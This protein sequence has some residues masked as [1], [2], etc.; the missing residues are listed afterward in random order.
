MG[1]PRLLVAYA[2]VDGAKTSVEI[3]QDHMILAPRDPSSLAAA[4]FPLLFRSGNLYLRAPQVRDR[5]EADAAA[6]RWRAASSRRLG[7]I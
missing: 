7:A 3:G 6:G 4:S 5:A 2:R 1:L